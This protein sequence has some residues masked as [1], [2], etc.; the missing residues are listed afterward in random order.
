MVPRSP[1]YAQLVRGRVSQ[2]TSAAPVAGALVELLFA[3]SVDVRG[4]SALSD[5]AG[6]FELRAPAAGR[7]RL[8]AKRIGVR[9]YEGPP[10][11]LG[12]GETRT[13][14]IVLAP[15][16]FRLPE[17]VVTANALCAVNPRESRR[18][19]SLW[20]EARTALDATEISLRDKLFSAEVTRYLRD[21][22]PK[23]LRVLDETQSSVRGVVTSP[24][25]AL[26]PD[27]L[28]AVGYWREAKD[29][30]VTYYG[31]DAEVLL[32]DAF[33]DD[34]CFRPVEGRGTR[35]GLV[36]LAFSPV[37]GRPVPDVAGTLWLDARTYEL[38]LVEFTYDRVRPGLDSAALGGELHFARLPNGAWL[39]RR[40]F[41]RV[42]VQGR[43]AQPLSTEGS[44]PWILLRSA[45]YRL[46]E[47]GGTVTTDA[48]RAPMKP[49]AISG[50]VH[51]STE[52]GA[53]AGAIV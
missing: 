39:V 25:N 19:A 27:S 52:K 2:E 31:P 50:V 16:Q 30:V 3:D 41:L 11:T 32:S 38:Q 24:F 20:D 51:D 37:A 7:Y 9:R 17:V 34:H 22:E 45:S 5:A 18:V 12:M 6:G 48:M 47:E 26:P 10:F 15:V 53:L 44:A 35:K 28:S 33:L 1:L 14:S 23:T 46:R 43:S 36:G 13:E 40:W 42:P 8:S 29:G 4:A 49:A 21:L